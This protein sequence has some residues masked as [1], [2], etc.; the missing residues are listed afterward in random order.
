METIV[1]DNLL[2]KIANSPSS[3]HYIDGL[4]QDCGNSIANAMEL[5]QSCTKPLIWSGYG[6]VSFIIHLGAVYACLLIHEWDCRM[7]YSLLGAKVLTPLQQWSNGVC[8]RE[9]WYCDEEFIITPAACSSAMKY[10]ML[11]HVPWKN[12]EN[13]VEVI[14]KK[15]TMLHFKKFLG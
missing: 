15:K 10:Q 14:L 11:T 3:R 1:I 13:F 7:V 4:V 6:G 2:W 12:N 9:A 5:P 8:L